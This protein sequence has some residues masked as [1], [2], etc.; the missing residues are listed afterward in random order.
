MAR[1]VNKKATAAGKGK[2]DK[3]KLQDIKPNKENLQSIKKAPKGI[4]KAVRD[5]KIKKAWKK[6]KGK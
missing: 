3:S 4:A 1:T 2:I 6:A 5:A